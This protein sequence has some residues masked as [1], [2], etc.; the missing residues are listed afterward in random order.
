MGVYESNME[1]AGGMTKGRLVAVAAV[2]P[3]RPNYQPAGEEG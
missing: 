3:G 2:V 1:E